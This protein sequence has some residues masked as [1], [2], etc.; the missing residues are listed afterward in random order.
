MRPCRRET[1]NKPVPGSHEE[2]RPKELPIPKLKEKDEKLMGDF[3]CG[4]YRES[5]NG[6]EEEDAKVPL[7]SVRV[8]VSSGLHGSAWRAT[9]R[10]R[11]RRGVG[12]CTER[13]V[14]LHSG[15]ADYFV[16]SRMLLLLACSSTENTC[17]PIYRYT[18]DM[19]SSNEDLD[20]LTTMFPKRHGALD[21]LDKR[22]TTMISTAEHLGS[23]EWILGVVGTWF[24]IP[25]TSMALMPLFFT[26][27]SVPELGPHVFQYS[28]N[29]S[30]LAQGLA[31]CES[32]SDK[33][34]RRVD[35][36]TGS[37]DTSAL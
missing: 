12:A 33:L 21:R 20:P 37:A 32:Q 3:A 1:S 6:K 27:S 7:S 18:N 23:G 4:A 13:G 35:I 36:S 11:R 31:L 5:R 14:A 22:L 25:V 28:V 2:G 8:L 16:K 17:P 15:R 19:A 29:C 26:C 9:R 34:R 24:G 30:P 10:R